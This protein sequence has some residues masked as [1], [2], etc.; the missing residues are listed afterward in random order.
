MEI[1]TI[2]GPSGVGKSTVSRRV[3]DSLGFTYLDTGAMYRAVGLFFY[4]QG[5]LPDA[6]KEI[7]PF[8][9][10][11][12]LSLYPVSGGDSGVLLNGEDV[13]HLIRTN[14]M[15][16]VASKVS[17]LPAVRLFLTGLQR[18]IGKSGN[19]VAEGRDMGTVVF[20]GA[21]YKFFLDADPQERCRRR[22]EQY[23][24]KGQKIDEEAILASII[25]RD[26]QD[27]ERDLAPLKKAEDAILIDTTVLGIDAVSSAILQR[28]RN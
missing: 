20:P 21:K 5:I 11:I 28:V 23:R 13:S 3:A 26:K 7:A 4:R 10:T 18:K 22:V 24:Q 19:I 8:L 12:D 9:A 14:E 25:K 17:A 27:R 6:E 16:M 1:V 2:D 15:S